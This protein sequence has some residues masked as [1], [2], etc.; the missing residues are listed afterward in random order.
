VLCFTSQLDKFVS[1]EAAKD[2]WASVINSFQRDDGFYEFA[3]AAQRKGGRL[4]HAAGYVPAGLSLLGRQPLRPNI[5]FEQ[6][7]STAS[8]WEPTVKGLLDVDVTKAPYN[9]TSGCDTGGA[10]A[11]NIASLLS[12]FIQTNSSTGGLHKHAGFVRW[13]LQYLTKQA[14]SATGLW[15]TTAQQQ[16][17]GLINCIGGSFHI[18]FVFQFIAQHPQ[19][20]Q[21]AAASARFPFAAAQLNSSLQLQCENGGWSPN[22]T[23]YIDVDGIYQATRPALQI[24]TSSKA[25]R[26]S[27]VREAC[28]RLMA[29]VVPV[30]NDRE[31]LLGPIS[32]VSH[33]L[34]ALVSAVA[35]CQK[36]WPEM[37]ATDRPWRMCL[38][39]VP[40]I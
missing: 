30:L 35:E 28:D 16:K 37:I 12:W 14:E 18:D 23:K 4:W 15:C 24:G 19:Y 20:G 25:S 3:D 13:Y 9:I 27:E 26:W 1:T 21:G 11:K 10:C 29:L 36:H 8:L 22:G 5:L 38:D 33:T 2:S 6:I 32:E 34:P 17:D 40:Y 39:D 31:R 7:A